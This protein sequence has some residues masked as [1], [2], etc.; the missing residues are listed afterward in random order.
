MEIL[1]D[2]LES[3]NSLSDISNVVP[4][5]NHP[6]IHRIRTGDYRLVV[7]YVDGNITILLLKYLKRDDNTYREYK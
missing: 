1:I 6:F 4:I 7:E 2:K 3:A 5:A